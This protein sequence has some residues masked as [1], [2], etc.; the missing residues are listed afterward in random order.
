MTLRIFATCLGL[1]LIA[2]AASAQT[3]T[4]TTAPPDK[5]ATVNQRLENQQDRIHNGTKDDQLTKSER[6]HLRAND[7]AIHAQEKVYQKAND[8]KL[9]GGERQQL[10]RELNQNSR[11]IY[12][13][14]HNK[15]KPR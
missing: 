4:P 7:A 11:K 2:T 6:T 9:T 10:N 3:T 1:G 8:G 13:D 14:R 15:R 12:R 5:P